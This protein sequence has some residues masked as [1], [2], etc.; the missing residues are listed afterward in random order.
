MPLSD[1]IPRSTI[2][3][4]RAG[5]HHRRFMAMSAAAALLSAQAVAAPS[6]KIEEVVVTATK[7]GETALQSTPLAISAFSAEQLSSRGVSDVRGL[8]DYTPGLQISDVN[9]YAQLYMRGVGSNNVFIGSDPSTTLHLD[10]VYLARPIAYFSDFLDVERVEVLRGPQGTLYGRNSVGGTINIVSRKPSDTL[11][12]EVQGSIGTYRELGLKGYVSGPLGDTPLR[13]SL[14]AVRLRHDGYLDNVADGADVADQNSYGLRGQLYSPL[15]DRAELTLRADYLH[16]DEHTA[17]ASKLLEPIGVPKDDAILGD[18]HKI[19]ANAPNRLEVRSYGVSA[20]FKYDF[21][22]DVSLKS[23]TAYR[24]VRSEDA[25]DSDGTDQDIMRALFNLRQHQFSEELNLN[26]NF[27]A[28][29]LVTGAYYFREADE[30]PANLAMPEFGFNHFQRPKLTAES[31]AL[32]AQGEY[33]F[34]DEL[35]VIAGLRYTR[36]TKDYDISD[37]WKLSGSPDSDIAMQAPTVVGMEPD[38]SDPFVVSSTKRAN[39]LTPKIGVNYKPNEDMLIYVSAT[40]GFKSGGFDFGASSPEKQADG[41]GPEYLWSYEVGL[42]SQWLDDRLRVN[43]DAFY[44]DYSDLQVTLYTQQVSAYTQNAATARVKGV[45]AE[46]LARPLPDLDLFANIAYLNARYTDYPGARDKRLQDFDASG[47][48]LNNSPR[49]T[50]AFG[51]TY[52]MHTDNSGDFYV[53]A[54]Y[55]YQTEQYFSPVND[56]VNGVRGWPGQQDNFGVLN[57]RL[58]WK[59]GDGLWDAALIGRNLTDREYITTAVPYGFKGETFVGRPG[60]PRTATFQVTRRFL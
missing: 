50:V 36:E 6:A 41:Y 19:A 4:R 21:T 44:Y 5:V 34:T 40:R 13:G 8:V 37:F 9:G 59:S 26:V 35:S 56:G 43:L 39:A 38:F 29:T 45:E 18:Y 10:G 55:H 22:D 42:K 49:W 48:Y 14:S 17:G 7:T 51:A 53:G 32:F 46:I 27:D 33:R 1:T 28:L 23:L 47:K 58:G 2:S 25:T 20:D 24:N 54:D 30:E 60:A 31:Y 52:T 15:G 11:T 3:S 12:G 57:A 16:S